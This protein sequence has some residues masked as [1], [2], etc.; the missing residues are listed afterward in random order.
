MNTLHEY[1]VTKLRELEGQLQYLKEI[2]PSL[3][4]DLDAL[5]GFSIGSK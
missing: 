2:D 3:E 5:L 1:T 4:E